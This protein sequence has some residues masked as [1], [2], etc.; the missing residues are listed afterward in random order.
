MYMRSSHRVFM[1]GSNLDPSRLRARIQHWDG[2]YQRA[3][4]PEYEL[5][6]NKRLSKGGVAANIMP[7]PSRRVWGILL[8]L[9]EYALKVLDRCEG[10]PS[11]YNRVALKVFLEDRSEVSAY[12]YVACPLHL[13]EA[14]MP[15]AKYLEY[16]LGGATAC[17][18]PS[19]YVQAIESLGKEIEPRSDTV[20]EIFLNTANSCSSGKAPNRNCQK[21]LFQ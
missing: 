11:H 4:L 15:S 1:Y 14:Q 13:V 9:D 17:G 19:D 3:L 12:V 7:H 20:G 5:C 8:E 2:Q 10:Y 6:F 18:L 21:S 16:V